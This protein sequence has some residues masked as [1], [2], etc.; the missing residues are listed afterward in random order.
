M[1][2]APLFYISFSI[3]MHVCMRAC[4][5]TRV[6]MNL[7]VPQYMCGG[8]RMTCGREFSPF[9]LLLLTIKQWQGASTHWAISLAS[10]QSCFASH[11][12]APW[13]LE[14]S[15]NSL[16]P[17]FHRDSPS[18]QFV[19]CSLGR[20]GFCLRRELIATHGETKDQLPSLHL[21]PLPQSMVM[22]CSYL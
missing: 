2:K 19:L 12:P 20:Y 16:L 6:H 22:N 3:C 11:A 7:H 10:T 4:V 9:T 14:L 17:A 21:R 18:L 15:A 5:C 1:P 13:L 8:H